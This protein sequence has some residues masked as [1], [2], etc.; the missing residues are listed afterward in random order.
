MGI[1]DT[2]WL[3][4]TGEQH[5]QVFMELRPYQI[6]VWMPHHQ[7]LLLADIFRKSLNLGL[8]VMV[9]QMLEHDY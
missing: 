4:Q 5:F 3:V 8:K 9:P 2:G 6:Q 1:D 7:K